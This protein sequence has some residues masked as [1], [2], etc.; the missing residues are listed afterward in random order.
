M[1]WESRISAE[2]HQGCDS[3]L[4]AAIRRISSPTVLLKTACSPLAQG[5]HYCL[6]TTIAHVP[7]FRTRTNVMSEDSVVGREGI[8]IPDIN[9]QLML[10]TDC[11]GRLIGTV[12]VYRCLLNDDLNSSTFHSVVPITNYTESAFSVGD[13]CSRPPRNA[14]PRSTNTPSTVVCNELVGAFYSCG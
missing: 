8:D 6:L 4:R 10:A 5:T 11:A 9:P 7:G 12:D 13:C 2:L 3:E 14:V 1:H